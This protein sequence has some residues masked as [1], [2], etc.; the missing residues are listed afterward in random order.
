MIRPRRGT[1]PPCRSSR[2]GSASAASGARS[3]SAAARS[4]PARARSQRHRPR[5]R[6]SD[7]R[8]RNPNPREARSASRAGAPGSARQSATA[9]PPSPSTRRCPTCEDGSTGHG[10]R[11]KCTAAPVAAVEEATLLLAVQRG[12]RRV[13]I[14]NDPFR[15]RF[16][17]LEKEIR[18]Q[19]VD[20]LRIGQDLPVAI[21]L[22]VVARLARLR[23][24]QRARTRQRMAPVALPLA[25]L[26]RHILA[27]RSQPETPLTDQRLEQVPDALLRATAGR[28]AVDFIPPVGDNDLAGSLVT[29]AAS[30]GSAAGDRTKRGTPA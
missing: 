22:R 12:V 11:R 28:P 26:T 18:Q 27:A 17:G 16:A 21:S 19:P 20:A 23:T 14:R 10:R 15:R 6:P 3:G 5:T 8:G 9:R 2:C 29:V 7:R 13:N 24:V 25:P 4:A 30:F 1:A